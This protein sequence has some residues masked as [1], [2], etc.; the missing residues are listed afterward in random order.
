[1]NQRAI[2]CDVNKALA[3]AKEIH[4]LAYNPNLVFIGRNTVW[5]R[6][7]R[8]RLEWSSYDPRSALPAAAGSN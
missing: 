6:L 7:H 4:P 1:M 3:E 8:Q 5:L 2:L